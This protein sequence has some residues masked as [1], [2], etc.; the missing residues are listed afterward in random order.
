M[1]MIS[2]LCWCFQ[3][4]IIIGLFQVVVQK[5]QQRLF[6]FVGVFT[7]KSGSASFKLLVKRHNNG[8]ERIQFEKKEHL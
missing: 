6:A 7:N 3:Q 1:G 4:K 2:R 5:I 8:D